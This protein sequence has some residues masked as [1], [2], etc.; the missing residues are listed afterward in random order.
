MR[1]VVKLEKRT[2]PTLYVEIMSK[3]AQIFPF[4]LSFK[5]Y[6]ASRTER[7]CKELVQLKITIYDISISPWHSYSVL[8]P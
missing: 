7:L 5:S 3:T 6:E 1:L 4:K 8:I 2:I